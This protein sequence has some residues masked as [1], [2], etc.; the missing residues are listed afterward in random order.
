M[1][2]HFKTILLIGCGAIGR[3]IL[4]YW[5]RVIPHVTSD[6]LV[7]IEP[8]DLPIPLPHKATHLQMGLTEENY[9]E[10]LD[11]I[12]PS[13]IIDLSINVD[14]VSIVNY[15]FDR[16]IPCINTA[17]ESWE[18]QTMWMNDLDM[19]KHSLKYRQDLILQTRRYTHHK[20]PTILID[21][22][23]NPGLITHFTKKCVE[24]L[25][26]ER[27]IEYSSLGEAAH[28]L[29]VRA[30]QC[31]EVDT[32]ICK[33]D[34]P[35]NMF[36]NTWSALG[37]IEEATDPCQV[38]WGSHEDPLSI[39]GTLYD[40]G[41]A[42]IP[43]RGMDMLIEGWNPLCG[44]Y[45]GYNIPHGENSITTQYFTHGD[46]K[47]SAYYV[48]RPSKPAI[49]SINNIRSTGY[50]LPSGEHV[51]V[52]DEIES[53]TDAVGALVICEDGTALWGGTI[54]SS[55]DVPEHLKGYTNCTCIQVGCGVLAGI[56]YISTHRNEGVITADHLDTDRVLELVSPH[57]GIVSYE[58][59]PVK[60]K[61]KF[62]DLMGAFL[63]NTI[64][65]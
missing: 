26:H 11:S 1:K 30:I 31:S 33:L 20:Q 16:N 21:H 5:N 62:K 54:L 27:E 12:K 52:G 65:T 50:T 39:P 48:Y 44:S 3:T 55:E 24:I 46:Y 10:T 59:A 47:P 36:L 7:I 25:A 9:I 40:V 64:P 63:Q 45:K 28:K 35:D 57:L 32:Q 49:E 13:F 17:L 56:D 38:G 41:M 2:S 23:M 4:L 37:F 22:G 14:S 15:C 60:M 58:Y 8:K 53:G 34:H 43:I 61:S 51:L 29:G 6:K 18:G 42:Y 19:F